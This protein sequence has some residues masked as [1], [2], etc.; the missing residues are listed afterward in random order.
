MA[1]VLPL[2]T[3]GAKTSISPHTLI[4]FNE[5]FPPQ[6][7]VYYKSSRGIILDMLLVRLVCRMN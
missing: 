1:L 2:V 5:Q 7:Q 6:I 4:S 3:Q